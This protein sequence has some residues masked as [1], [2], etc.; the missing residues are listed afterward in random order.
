MNIFQQLFRMA[1]ICMTVRSTAVEHGH[2]WAQA[3]LQ[4]S[5]AT[6]LSGHEGWWDI[7]LSLYYKFTAKSVGERIL[8]IDQHLAKWEA[9]I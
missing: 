8:K 6:H 7:L 5:V 1:E 9:K 2:I 3:F 4:G